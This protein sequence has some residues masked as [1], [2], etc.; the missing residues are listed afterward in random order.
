LVIKG[1]REGSSGAARSQ[2]YT[3]I[4]GLE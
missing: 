2:F 1:L 4:N 3:Q